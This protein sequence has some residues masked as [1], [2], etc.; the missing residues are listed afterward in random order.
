MR[1]MRKANDGHAAIEVE[2]NIL[3]QLADFDTGMKAASGID[4]A[5]LDRLYPS[6]LIPGAIRRQLGKCIPRLLQLLYGRRLG[7]VDSVL[8]K[9][10]PVATHRRAGREYSKQPS[11]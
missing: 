9:R 3:V 8:R 10:Q 1:T 7:I 11:R 4:L 2:Q 6:H 5:F